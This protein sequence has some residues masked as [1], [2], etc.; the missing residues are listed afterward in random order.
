MPLGMPRARG[1]SRAGSAAAGVRAAT[2]SATTPPPSSAHVCRGSGTW[3]SFGTPRRRKTIA[4]GTAR[5]NAAA[6]LTR[7]MAKRSTRSSRLA[8]SSGS[9]RATMASPRRSS[10]MRPSGA[11]ATREAARSPASF[12][13][14]MASSAETPPAATRSRPTNRSSTCFTRRP[15]RSSCSPFT[16]RSVRA[17]SRAPSACSDVSRTAGSFRSSRCPSATSRAVQ[18]SS[19]QR[20]STLR[21]PPSPWRRLEKASSRP[22][23]LGSYTFSS[24]C[25]RWTVLAPTVADSTVRERATSTR[26]PER[27]S[28]P[29]HDCEYP[30]FLPSR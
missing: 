5:G 15:S 17:A 22:P 26:W 18:P 12:S 11:T 2:V 20:P 19:E 27:V 24:A 9:A 29:T 30:A 10:T 1:A 8:V 23:G 13:S 28:K 14:T 21:S 7:V 4:A 25:D 3:N 6:S 16:E